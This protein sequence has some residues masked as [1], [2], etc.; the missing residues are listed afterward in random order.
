[1]SSY[2]RNI[3]LDFAAVFFPMAP[4]NMK[5][6]FI[7]IHRS[8]LSGK[9]YSTRKFYVKNSDGSNAESVSITDNMDPRRE[10]E[11]LTNNTAD[12]DPSVVLNATAMVSD[13]SNAAQSDKSKELLCAGLGE[14][15]CM[16]PQSVVGSSDKTNA[17]IAHLKVLSMLHLDV[18][19]QQQRQIQV[20]E[21]ETQRLRSENET[22]SA[23]SNDN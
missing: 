9:S 23:S 4:G 7:G 19:E 14:G 20:F 22:V 5:S 10:G 8:K 15:G 12:A 13:V 1:M 17:E 2:L 21:R 16:G 3:F 6:D 18:I 11:T